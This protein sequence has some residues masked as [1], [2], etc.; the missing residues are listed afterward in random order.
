MPLIGVGEPIDAYIGRR[1]ATSQAVLKVISKYNAL[2][3][4]LARFPC[5]RFLTVGKV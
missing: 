5:F 2:K 4:P 3:Q 1:Y